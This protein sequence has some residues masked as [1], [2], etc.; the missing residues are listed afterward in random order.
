MSDGVMTHE[1]HMN[2]LRTRKTV[3]KYDVCKFNEDFYNE[4]DV[5]P[6]CT[7]C[8]IDGSMY[9]IISSCDTIEQ[10]EEELKKY[11]P[12]VDFYSYKYGVVEYYILKHEYDEYGDDVTCTEE[13]CGCNMIP[14]NWRE[15]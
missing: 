3:I 4:S 1:E 7:L 15:T 14:E 2:Y 5:E 9:K 10:A 12:Y 8:R 6:G 11:K 13:T